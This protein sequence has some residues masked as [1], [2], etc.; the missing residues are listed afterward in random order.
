VRRP[1]RRPSP[2]SAIRPASASKHALPSA[3]CPN[4]AGAKPKDWGA[5]LQAGGVAIGPVWSSRWCRCLDTARLAFGHAEPAPVLDS[6]FNDDE[7]ASQAKAEQTIPR[8]VALR[9]T[10]RD[11]GNVALVT[12]DVNIR[13]L[14]R[15]AVAPGG[16]VVAR[17]EAGRLAVLG[18][19]GI[20][21]AAPGL[22]ESGL[23]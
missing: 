4:A 3:T 11:R 22:A 5:A 12:H 6:M 9:G 19:L 15:E 7:A 23:C 20:G 10:G 2:A 21:P 14:T 8:L 1:D 13:A 18:Q 17:M 16:V